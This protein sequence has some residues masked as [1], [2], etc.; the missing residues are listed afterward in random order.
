M[1]FVAGP[2]FANTQMRPVSGNDAGI[3]VDSVDAGDVLSPQVTK[4]SGNPF[5]DQREGELPLGEMPETGGWGV[6]RPTLG[7]MLIMLA[8]LAMARRRATP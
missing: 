6:L 7:G 5:D 4:A 3:A 8:G 2:L 1:L